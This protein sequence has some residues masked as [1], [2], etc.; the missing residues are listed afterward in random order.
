MRQRVGH[1][2]LRPTPAAL[3][4]SAPLQGP[5]IP[6][7]ELEKLRQDGSTSGAAMKARARAL[8]AKGTSFKR[9]NKHRPMEVSSKKPVPVFR[10]V[11]QGGKR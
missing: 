8:K 11:F 7:G 5:D 4:P 9:E 1:R 2:R 6:L 10:E 3:A